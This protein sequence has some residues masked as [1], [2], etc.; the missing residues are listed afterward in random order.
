LAVAGKTKNK[1]NGKI[2]RNI[3]VFGLAVVLIG[4]ALITTANTAQAAV[5][6]SN[7]FESI[8]GSEWSN[9]STDVT[10]AGSRR[11]LGQFANDDA[12]SLSLDNLPSHQSVTVSFDLYAIQSWDGTNLDWG[13]DIW[14]LSVV[15]GPVLLNTTFSNTGEDGHMQS[16]PAFDSSGEE[17]PAY[18][19]AAQINT[20]G[21]KFYGDSVYSLSFTFGHS[22]NS[23]ALNFV[24]F[25][26]QDVY[27]E[28]W[29]IDNI[30]ISAASGGPIP[31]PSTI[32][33]LSLGALS[34]IRKKR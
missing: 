12:V 13:P 7:N 26:L 9:T 22:G 15:N 4:I 32:G 5:I 31:E 8:V 19:G 34:L 33:I 11:F 24:G 1:G 30:S 2:M 14:R 23:L 29:G 27:D 25:G 6:Y 16:Y 3:I 21:Y 28:S 17:Y 10:P 20:L 18:T